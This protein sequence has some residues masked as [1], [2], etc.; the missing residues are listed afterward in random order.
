VLRAAR[1]FTVRDLAWKQLKYSGKIYFAP[2]FTGLTLLAANQPAPPDITAPVK[3]VPAPGAP[4]A[5][6]DSGK[7]ASLALPPVYTLTGTDFQ[8]INTPRDWNCNRN[9]SN[10]L[11]VFEGLSKFRLTPENFQVGSRT[12]ATI[13]FAP[14]PDNPVLTA[15]PQIMGANG[16]AIIS[17]GTPGAII[18]YTVNGE[19]PTPDPS[20]S[21]YYE[22]SISLKPS[23]TTIESI[24]V[25]PNHFP[26]AVAIAKV[27]SN[28]PHHVMQISSSSGTASQLAYKSYRFVW[29]TAS[30]EPVEWDLPV[31]QQTPATVTASAILN[32]SD[33]TEI[34]F[35]NIQPLDTAQPITFTYDGNVLTNPAP[36]FKYNPAAQTVKIL[37]TSAMTAKPGHKELLLNGYTLAPGSATPAAVQIELPF[38]VTKR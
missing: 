36:V 25:A 3:P 19:S 32:E 28:G 5:N 12:A 4:P 35:S 15:T 26:S 11:E 2:T 24:A 33:S 38:D 17:D 7:P 37:I 30:G 1:S 9:F 34:T 27:Q 14:A 29:H 8:N 23:E 13:T 10:C 22:G 20:K 6:P 18:F 31:P 21:I 16:T